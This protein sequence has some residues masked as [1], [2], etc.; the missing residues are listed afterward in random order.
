MTYIIAFICPSVS[1][2]AIYN[3]TATNVGVED[4]DSSQFCNAGSAQIKLTPVADPTTI[5]KRLE[6]VWIY[7][8]TAD[9]DKINITTE[10]FTKETIS[11]YPPQRFEC[12]AIDGGLA[13]V[14]QMWT[15]WPQC[16]YSSVVASGQRC[17][18]LCKNLI[19][20]NVVLSP[21]RLPTCREA[22]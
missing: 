22:P 9:S 13:G 3:Y 8:T 7:D 18:D 14:D 15:G 10:H 6:S 21:T 1:L 4:E 12:R 5:D 16:D 20:R 11:D 19:R 2:P 17:S